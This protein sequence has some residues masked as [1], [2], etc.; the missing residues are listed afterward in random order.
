MVISKGQETVSERY[1]DFTSIGPDSLAGRFIRHFWQP[2]HLTEN[3]PAGRIKPLRILGEDF[4]LFRGMGGA[5]HVVGPRCAHRGVSLAIGRVEG[6]CLRCFYHGWKY[7]SD[8]QCVEAPAEREGFPSSA[9][10]PSYPTRDYLGLVF[11]YL[12]EGEPPPFPRFTAIEQDGTVEAV[13]RQRDW[14]YFNQLENSVDEV[15]FNFAHRRSKFTDVGLND[16]IPELDGRET[17]YGILRIGR[18]GD[19]ERHSHIVMPNCMFSMTYDD[20]TGWIE[21]VAWRVPVEDHCHATFIL[22]CLHKDGAAMEAY[23][24]EKARRRELLEKM[25]PIESVVERILRGELH[26]DEVANRPDIIQVQDAVVLKSQGVRPDRDADHLATSD[27][28]VALLR[29]IWTRELRAI[30]EGREI[31]DWRL[32][33]GLAPTT[34]LGEQSSA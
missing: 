25:E 12:G 14:S 1:P 3:L 24:H 23:R 17:E 6:D 19:T 31:K 5:A 13:E 28:Q 9:R 18:R 29:Q 15:H 2:V 16:E 11:A 7:D 30:E 4:T 27:R 33:E 10:I 22:N 32:P 26:A 20:H 34:G 21:H 8:G